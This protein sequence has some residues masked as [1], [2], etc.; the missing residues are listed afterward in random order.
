MYV[1]TTQLVAGT[2][3][4]SP[5]KMKTSSTTTFKPLHPLSIICFTSTKRLGQSAVL[6]FMLR[7]KVCVVWTHY[8]CSVDDRG[9]SLIK[10][11]ECKSSTLV[12]DLIGMSS[13]MIR[14]HSSHKKWTVKIVLRQM[15]NRLVT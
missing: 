2:V 10:L 3:M 15:G 5:N 13:R 14:S 1:I 11:F 6:F 9:R 12:F 4:C 7:H 8:G